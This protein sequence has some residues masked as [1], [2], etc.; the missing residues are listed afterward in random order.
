MTTIILPLYF[1]PFILLLF[2][3]TLIIG[4]TVVLRTVKLYKSKNIRKI[5][6]LIGLIISFTLYGFLYSLF[7]G[8]NNDFGR[9]MFGFLIMLFI[10][11]VIYL[12]AY[13]SKKENFISTVF[14][15]SIAC[16]FTVLISLF[17]F[18]SILMIVTK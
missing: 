5:D 14:L 12:I 11:F 16:T 3:V 7:P 2:G 8:E 10:P 4:I 15:I 13:N 17:L 18:T 1:A 6:L 9:I